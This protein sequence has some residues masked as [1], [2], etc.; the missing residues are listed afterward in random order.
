MIGRSPLLIPAVVAVLLAGCG[1]SGQQGVSPAPTPTPSATHSPTFPPSTVADLKALAA[2]G[3][4]SAVREVKSEGA[5]LPSCPQP[6]RSVV[7]A[8]SVSDPKQIAAALLNYFYAQG[9]DNECG[10]LVLAY[11]NQGEID[12]PYTVGQVVLNVNGG[13]PK[14]DLTVNVGN[15]LGST[16][17]SFEVQY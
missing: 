15:A 10:S 13:S 17:L 7:V 1:G 11:A 9:L 12:G 5:G 14:H 16:S 8:S 2:T 3:D 4:A 6:K